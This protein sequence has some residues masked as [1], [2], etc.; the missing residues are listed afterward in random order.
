[1]V[2]VY[3]EL[4]GI[5]SKAC[6]GFG[7]F[8]RKSWM[9]IMIRIELPFLV[10][11]KNTTFPIEIVHSDVR[12]PYAIP[13]IKEHEGEFN[14]IEFYEKHGIVH[15]LSCVKAS[16]QNGVV[17]R[18]HQY[19]L[20]VARAL[21]FQSSLP[22]CF[23]GE[24]I[25]IVTHIINK[26]STKFLHDK[27]SYELLFSK[28]PSYDHLKVFGSYALY[29]LKHKTKGNLIKKTIK[30]V[31][32]RYPSG[33][34]VY[35]VYDISANKFL[36]SRNIVF[37]EHIFPFQTSENTIDH[38]SFPQTLGVHDFNFD[39]SAPNVVNFTPNLHSSS[40]TSS[41][42]PIP[43]PETSSPSK[44]IDISQNSI[45]SILE[46]S[47]ASSVSA[48]IN[49]ITDIISLPRKS[50]RP[51]HVPKYFETYHIDLPSTSYHVTSHLITK[52][53]SFGC[54]LMFKVK[55]NAN[56]TMERYKARLVA[57]GYNQVEGFYYQETFS[58]I[59]KQTTIK[60]FM[61]TVAIKRDFIALLVYVDDIVI[62]SI[63]AQL[64]NQEKK[65]LSSQFKLRDLGTVKYFLRFEIARGPKGISI[66][67][68]NYT[69][70]LLDEYGL[71]GTKLVTT[72]I[73][74][75]HKLIKDIDRIE[76]ANPTRYK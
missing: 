71:L 64:T 15:Q 14:L 18:K 62:A 47:L 51:R 10:H 37:H 50:C 67:Q 33:I 42:T 59:T 20:V 2:I 69:L 19:L 38:H 45:E 32:V 25:L 56:G 16:Q 29:P 8:T 60:V 6:S 54:K 12:G 40:E 72:P 46:H 57:K 49:L 26:I 65:Y 4:M 1:M 30:C 17:E 13:T 27:S 55:I 31:F 43:S 28:P 3:S 23:W 24:T 36:I 21:M 22:I 73:D 11:I 5:S 7:G 9:S 53:L 48:P 74:Y 44:F 68:K 35:N 63:N 70:D 75:S 61:A 76:V 66:C 41:C 39:I 34:K 52:I 58:P